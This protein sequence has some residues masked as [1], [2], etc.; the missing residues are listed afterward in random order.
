MLEVLVLIMNV[1]CME[2]SC[3][4]ITVE[5]GIS[6]LRGNRRPTVNCNGPISND[7]PHWATLARYRKAFLLM[8]EKK[9]HMY[10]D[11][12]CSCEECPAEEDLR[13]R[14]IEILEER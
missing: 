7:F 9:Y 2:S 3:Y 14:P 5:N 1:Y 6:G 4:D 8:V 12:Y 10:E 13:H 11:Q